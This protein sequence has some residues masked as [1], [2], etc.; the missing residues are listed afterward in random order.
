MSV[1]E[2]VE[3]I[4]E[5]PNVNNVG[6]V[7]CYINSFIRFSYIKPSCIHW[8]ISFNGNVLSKIYVWRAISISA[9]FVAE[10]RHSDSGCCAL[11]KKGQTTLKNFT[12]HRIKFI[13][14]L[15]NKQ[16]CWV[17][18]RPLFKAFCFRAHHYMLGTL[19]FWGRP[20]LFFWSLVRLRQGSPNLGT[21][22]N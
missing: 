15:L 19:P 17:H 8:Y 6:E 11:L 16:A 5:W 3:F 14:S 20:T 18:Y 12:Q 22:A 21:R 10:C 13:K 2:E 9:R 7:L 4:L 1:Y